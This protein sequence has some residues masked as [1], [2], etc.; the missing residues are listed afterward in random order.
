MVNNVKFKIFLY[1]G[2]VKKCFGYEAVSQSEQTLFAPR[3]DAASI[4]VR[5]KCESQR[6]VL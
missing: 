2:F 1:Y 5:S 3:A 4:L 6:N